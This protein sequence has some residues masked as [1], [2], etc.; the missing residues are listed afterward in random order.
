M[1]TS[2]CRSTSP[3]TPSKRIVKNTPISAYYCFTVALTATATT[4]MAP[5]GYQGVCGAVPR[6]DAAEDGGE[7]HPLARGKVVLQGQDE[8]AGA[9]TVPHQ[10]GQ[11]NL[12]ADA[13]C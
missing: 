4:M 10:T 3:L 8:T 11:E 5:A 12:V 6:K 13:A 2:R 7:R 1:P 9:A